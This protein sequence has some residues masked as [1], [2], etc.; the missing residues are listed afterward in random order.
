VW[1]LF[2]NQSHRLFLFGYF[3]SMIFV[4][5]LGQNAHVGVLEVET[6]Q[7]SFFFFFFKIP[8]TLLIG[9]V[10]HTRRFDRRSSQIQSLIHA[11]AVSNKT[12][13]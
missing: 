13:F 4:G 10:N 6:T 2:D 12:N 11:I 8:H 9:A 3:D 1:L 5:F 7:L